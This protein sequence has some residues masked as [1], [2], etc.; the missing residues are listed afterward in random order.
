MNEN[1]PMNANIVESLR[2]LAVPIDTVHLDPANARTGHALDRIAASL[3]QYGQRKP[4]VVNRNESNK[5]EA[6]NGTWQAAKSLGWSH[7]AVVFV[8][9]DPQTAVGYGI[10]DNRLGDLST[11]DAGVLQTLVGSLEP[12]METGFGEGELMA[13]VG[14]LGGG[15]AVAPDE[16]P[17]Y[18]ESI[19]DTVEYH[20]CPNCNHKWPK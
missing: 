4:I 18:D 5:I 7:I 19:A 8:E 6:G 13:L 11:W 15:T 3:Q 1:Y 17:E 10:A 2:P 12:E 14:E 20:E 16:W 9:D